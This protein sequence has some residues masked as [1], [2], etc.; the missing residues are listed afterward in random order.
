VTRVVRVVIV[1]DHDVFRRGLHAT[2]SE[3][4]TLAVVGEAG[5]A[6]RGFALVSQT[7]PDVAL[8]DLQM[9][10]KD[11][12]ALAEDVRRAGM[13]T[14]LL[15]LTTFDDRDRI[16]RFFGAGGDG[17]LLKGTR[18]QELVQAIVRC[19][20]GE[21]V[22]DNRIARQMIDL[23]RGHVPQEASST[24][25]AALSTRERE[26]LRLLGRGASN[27][28]IARALFISEGTV[29]NHVTV[30]LRKLDVHDRTQAALLAVRW[31]II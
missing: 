12:I 24:I 27:R 14:R 11:G 21:G 19:A 5:D 16:G 6:E 7:R 26:V 25:L 1:D 23:A 18:A 8:V 20:D 29:K 13:P 3:E 17:F 30:I 10:G 15:A 9:P 28:E 22:I 4:P 2:L 31:Q